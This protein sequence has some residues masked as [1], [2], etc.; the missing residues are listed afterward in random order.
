M[1]TMRQYK[2]AVVQMDSQENKEENMKEA[3]RYIDE[4]AANGAKMVSFPE[5]MNQIRKP[6][7]KVE[8][9]PI[10]GYTSDILC[11]KAKEHGIYI[12]SGSFRELIPGEVKYYNTGIMIDPQGEI[13]GEY[14]KLHT[15]DITL[16]D[17]TEAQESSRVRPGHSIVTVDTAL[18]KF[19]MSIC[20]DIR[21]SELYRLMAL[22]GA[23]IL[24]TPANFTVPT[25]KD[26][27]EPILRTRAIEN[28]CYVVAAGQ[29][30]K[31]AHGGSSYGKSMV[32]DPWGTI[33]AC[34]SD[35]P[36]VVYAEIDLDYLDSIRAKL[37]SLENRRSDVYD[38]KKKEN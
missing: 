17:G 37:R 33:V 14:R 20:Y 11:A 4:A 5:V 28:G 9:E 18:G 2:I 36:C 22:E 35:R 29:I 7:E 19:G 16:P 27:W 31:K 38:L 1:E 21:F 23:Q 34:A 32:I 6:G 12:H 26:H 10:P 30:G 8:G 13:I 15:F 24:L 3:V 25:G